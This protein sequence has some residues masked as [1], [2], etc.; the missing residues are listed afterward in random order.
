MTGTEAPA[1]WQGGGLTRSTDTRFQLASPKLHLT[2]DRPH[3]SDQLAMTPTTVS[4]EE[5]IRG[6]AQDAPR[7]QGGFGAAYEGGRLHGSH[8]G[9]GRGVQEGQV[10]PGG[11]FWVT[12]CWPQQQVWG[13]LPLQTTFS[14]SADR[15]SLFLSQVLSYVD[16]YGHLYP[17]QWAMVVAITN[18]LTREAADWV[19]DLHSDHA[20]ELVDIGLFLEALCSRFEDDT[21]TQ[22]LEGELVALKQKVHSARE[23]I[24]EFRALAGQLRAWPEWLLVHHFR[25][26]LDKEIK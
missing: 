26:G 17:S 3:P 14:G 7:R 9:E 13:P 1:T 12:G 18:V 2:T 21:R 19:A 11:P 8:R 5:A 24:K 15:V 16:L 22:A 6:V 4:L 25:L 20:R 23:Y 10:P